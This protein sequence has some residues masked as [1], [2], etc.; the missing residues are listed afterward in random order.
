MGDKIRIDSLVYFVKNKERVLLVG[1][2]SETCEIGISEANEIQ[3]ELHRGY[4]KF[5]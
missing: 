2:L 4:R 3:E 5:Q 1:L